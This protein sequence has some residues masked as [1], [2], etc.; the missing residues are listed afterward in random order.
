MI[1]DLGKSKQI[2]LF[3]DE[4]FGEKDFI[5]ELSKLK[6][7]D[8]LWVAPNSV[9]MITQ[10]EELN[11]IEEFKDFELQH[12]MRNSNSIIEEVKDRAFKVLCD[13]KPL[14]PC[15]LSNFPKGLDI[16]QVDTLK[17]AIEKWKSSSMEK[18]NLLVIIPLDIFW[19]KISTAIETGVIDN[20]IDT[21]IYNIHTDTFP[22]EQSSICK[23][24]ENP[25]K[26]LKTGYN[27][28]PKILFTDRRM[29]TGFEWSTVVV[30]VGDGVEKQDNNLSQN[31][32]EQHSC[33]SIMRCTTQLILVTKD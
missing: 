2:A 23:D 4:Y 31:E 30:V 24:T 21:K 11:G 27:G 13:F 33:N 14:I 22:C 17:E 3:L 1:E 12:N 20:T 32:I 7:V 10:Y 25:V 29:V 16:I 15:E 9:S 28:H 8:I 26:Y 5:Q 6:S 18:D 19:D